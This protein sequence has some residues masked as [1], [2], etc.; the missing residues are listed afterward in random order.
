MM[1]KYIVDDSGNVKI[2]NDVT[3]WA[4]WFEQS[5]EKKF[6]EGG[7][8]VAHTMLPNGIVVSTVFLGLDHNFMKEGPPILF[9]TM[10]FGR[11]NSESDCERY[12]TIEDARKGHELMVISKSS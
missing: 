10:A 2:E 1:E 9:E 11:N 6:E 3:T 8:R 4:N 5:G 7:R 12:S